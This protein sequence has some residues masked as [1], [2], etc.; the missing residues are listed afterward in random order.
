MS[1]P[2]ASVPDPHSAEPI[3][4]V[5]VFVRDLAGRIL[6]VRK[7][8]TDAFMQPGGKPEPGESP[9]QTGIR[10]LAEELGAELADLRLL[11]EWTAA[12]ANEAG[13]LVQA[14][15]FSARL[16]RMSGVQAEI[17]ELH[18]YDP[19]A[20]DIPAE[21]LAPLLRDVVLP[22]V[23]PPPPVTV[24]GIGADGHLAPGAAEAVADAEVLLGGRR[25]L[26]LV[27]ERP[28]QVRRPWPSPLAEAL[29]SL[30]AEVA[31]RR[32]VVLASGDPLLSGIGTTLASLV[33]NRLRLLPTVS[34]VALARA[35]TGWSAEETEVV[36]VVGRDLDVLRRQLAPG[37][38]L[39]V[40]SSDEHTPA[41]IAQLVR[42]E[43]HGG[44]EVVVLGDLGSAAESRVA[45]RA[46]EEAFW[47]EARLPRLNVVALE[48]VGPAG[49]SWSTGLRDELFEH[50]G[51]LTKRDVRAGALSRLEP[52]PGLLLWDVGAGAGSVGIEWMRA[53]PTCR[54]IAVEADAERGA[55]IDRNAA[56]LGVPGLEV[57]VGR[58]PD[59]LGPL[60]TPD[61]IFVGGGATAAGLIDRCA[62]RLRPGGRLVVHGV[63]VETEA[64][65]L[66]S[67]R[68]LGGELTRISVER[69]EPL[70][71][72]TGFT[73]ARAV[74]Q[75]AWTKP[76]PEPTTDGS[77]DR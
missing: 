67:Y 69:A 49:N 61:A 1:D 17:E 11:G 50:D 56:R 74:T 5:A 65:L 73:P 12:A 9:E 55:R 43:G 37:R 22:W 64:E 13:R 21:R 7:R 60:P 8:G 36:T 70:G 48:V 39:L 71:T 28:D 40:L 53:H 42:E 24:V 77:V 75:W 63:T 25:H 32:V 19:A 76:V 72:F 16:V 66:A 57:V 29:P 18:W 15:V 34:S 26:S 47:A 59:A 46:A 3:R 38:R 23:G 62:H 27:P 51:Q 33:G 35:R 52:A 31:E 2:A 54:T 41:A 30:L 20:P 45:A 14:V 68:R 44:T 10:E 4:V 6:T 58:A